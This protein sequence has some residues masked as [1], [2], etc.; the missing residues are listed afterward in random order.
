[1]SRDLDKPAIGIVFAL[2]VLTGALLTCIA[3]A[4]T[5]PDALI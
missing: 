5:L 3:V 2:G 4:A 1:M